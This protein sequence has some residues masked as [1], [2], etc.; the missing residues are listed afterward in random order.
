LSWLIA[1]RRSELVYL[2]NAVCSNG[3]GLSDVDLNICTTTT[4]STTTQ[5]TPTTTKKTKP[6]QKPVKVFIA[7]WIEK[8][9][10]AA[11]TY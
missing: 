10:N 2:D 8:F 5:S 3:Y 11:L 7:T 9:L 4:T 1:F 6:N